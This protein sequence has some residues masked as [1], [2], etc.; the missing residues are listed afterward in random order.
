MTV[1]LTP[2]HF[3]T[4]EIKL[5]NEKNYNKATSNPWLETTA[6]PSC[7]LP[8]GG[9]H[10]SFS[11]QNSRRDTQQPSLMTTLSPCPACA[12]L[13]E[14]RLHGQVRLRWLFS[15]GKEQAAAEMVGWHHQLNEYEFEQALGISE[16]LKGSPLFRP[17]GR[18][19]P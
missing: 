4:V 9:R 16:R 1:A 7:Q 18:D 14:E 17:E 11:K 3:L 19:G 15:P 6:T 2:Y 8:E 10:I 5:E 13:Q 12:D